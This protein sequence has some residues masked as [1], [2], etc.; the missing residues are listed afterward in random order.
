MVV[1]G[2]TGGIGAGKSTVASLLARRGAGVIDVD[3]LGREVLCRGQP[4]FAPVLARFG[5]GVLGGDGEIDRA[6]LAVQVFG[7]PDELEALTSISHPAINEA[8]AAR[9]ATCTSLVVVLDMAVLVESSLGRGLYQ[10]VVVVEAPWPLR[11]ARLEA[12]G[13]SEHEA[14]ARRDAQASDEQRRA[15]A[16][17]VIQ[18]DGDLA[19]LGR[20]VGELWRELTAPQTP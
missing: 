3:A 1:V 4:A 8:L 14:L 20:A 7:H 18:N 19:A 9:L 13:L 10:V 6:K 15:V 11:L 12:R 16:T 2:L 5:P 17:R